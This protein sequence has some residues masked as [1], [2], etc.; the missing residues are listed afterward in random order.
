MDVNDIF[1]SAIQHWRENKG[2]GTAFI[3][4]SLDA[5]WLLYDVLQ[6]FYAKSTG[7]TLIIVPN[8][9]VRTEIVE[10][11]TH[12]D[13]EENNAEFKKLLD[14]KCI[15]V[16][17]HDFVEHELNFV[18]HTVS[19]LYKCDTLGEN[20][21]KIFN[22][23][24]FK[25]AILDRLF[26]NYD[27]VKKLYDVAH[28]LPDFKQNEV[29]AIRLST[30]V[31]EIVCG[32]DL[33]EDSEDKKLLNYYNEY[34]NASMNIFGS[35][36]RMNAARSGDPATHLSSAQICYQIA[37]ENGWSPTLDMTA[38]F[39]ISLDNTYN[40]NKILDR[41]TETFEM[42]RKRTRLL[43]DNNV[44][45]EK[46][47]EIV[48]EHKDEKILIIS[49]RG[50]FAS[51][52][53]DYLNNISE[54]IICGN[55]HDKAEPMLASDVYGNP[56]YI[57][58]GP[59]KGERR[60]YA[61][62]AQKSMS[63]ISFNNDIINVISTSNTPDKS[64]NIEVDVVIITSPICETI[65]SYMYRLNNVFFRNSK[66]RLYTLYIMQS[67]EETKLLNRPATATHTII[68]EEQ[69]ISIKENNFDFVVVD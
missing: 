5:K 10:Y 61:A 68:N 48:K 53:T 22:S 43:S 7:T 50:E 51:K 18:Y 55:Y 26:P 60:T 56:I 33:P 37:Y 24:N 36:D 30:P 42:I 57:K 27:D 20:V 31:E 35:F 38:S 39:N 9:N 69:N 3:P 41:A 4:S 14:D 62:Q 49:K 6:R 46:I 58:S 66:L 34:I 65:E 29:D 16:F 54:K 63:Q 2:K 13:S 32:I 17:T 23:G 1:E 15:K 8:F 47:L 45:L 59:H 12:Q 52:I 28:L 44:K 19:I 67:L 40:P 64:L 11:L 21:F 25:L